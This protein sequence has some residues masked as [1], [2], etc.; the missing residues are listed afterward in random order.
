MATKK[1][2]TK[3][4]AK[5][6]AKKTRREG[7]GSP[8]PTATKKTAKKKTPAKA[9]KKATKK[10]RSLPTS[11]KALTTTLAATVRRMWAESVLAAMQGDLRKSLSLLNLIALYV[12]TSARVLRS[13][14]N[15]FDRLGRSADRDADD[16]Y[17]VRLEALA[18][19]KG[20]RDLVTDLL[21]AKA[22]ATKQAKTATTAKT[23]KK[24]KKTPDPKLVEH[25]I[26]PAENLYAADISAAHARAAG[27]E[28]VV[29][30]DDTGPLR[31]VI[32]GHNTKGAVLFLERDGK[33]LGA[34]R[35]SDDAKTGIYHL[36]D[37]DDAWS[38]AASMM[39][40]ILD[41]FE[42]SAGYDG[43]F[44]DDAGDD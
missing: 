39:E 8:P 35:T 11:Q 27:F 16:A 18:A 42:E 1:K 26:T 24:K 33:M 40:E 4:P 10:A 30:I 32:G 5:K 7:R 29:A 34:E 3:K 2:P 6:T 19:Q 28:D 21:D 25:T 41:G 9:T 44:D 17:A 36:V 43:D 38:E 14:R 22:A 13:R 23:A 37:E 15:L 12:P 31:L 20:W